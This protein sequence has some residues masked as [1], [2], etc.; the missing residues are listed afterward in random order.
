M[1][2]KYFNNLGPSFMDDVFK[3]AGEHITDTRTSL[4]KLKTTFEKNQSRTKESFLR[5][6]D[7]LE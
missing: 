3:S 4:L 2:F 6:I 5:G 1:T 7:Y